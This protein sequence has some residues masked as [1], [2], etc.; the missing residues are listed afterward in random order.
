MLLIYTGVGKG[1]TSAAIGASVRCVGWGKKVALVQFIKAESWPSG[2]REVLR[3]LGVDVFVMG[4][5]W[6]GIMGDKRER[7]E[8][9][10]AAKKAVGKV[11]KLLSLD[12]IKDQN[13]KIK[14]NNKELSSKIKKNC[15]YDLI[16]CD[17][18]LGA[19]HGGLIE[20]EDVEEILRLALLSQNE[21]HTCDIIFTGQNAPQWLIEKADLVTEMK[22][23]KHPYEVGVL[24]KKGIDY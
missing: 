15:E 14:N 9:Q 22:K 21:N 20:K 2:E 19:L 23:I 24:A 17:E 4:K 18:I 6:V 16:V 3:N 12:K 8:H 7:S 5:S 10:D 13:S 1:K 11:L